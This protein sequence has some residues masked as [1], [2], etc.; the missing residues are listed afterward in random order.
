MKTLIKLLLILIPVV[1][2]ILSCEEDKCADENNM[3]VAEIV[4]YNYNCST[5]ILYFPNDTAKIKELLGASRHN[6]YQTVNLSQSDFEIGQLINV[7]VRPPENDELRACITLHPSY[8]YLNVYVSDYELYKD[9]YFIDDIELKYGECKTVYGQSTLCFDTVLED[10]RCPDGAVCVWEGNAKVQLALSGIGMGKHS[11]ELNTNQSFP[12]DTTI[13]HLNI[14]LVNV[15]PYPDINTVIKPEDYK[16]TLSVANIS[17]IESNAQ[18]LSF[19]PNKALCSWGW[20][21]KLD[22]DTIKSGDVLIGKTV[23]YEIN[24]PIDVFIQLGEK[25]KYCSDYYDIDRIIRI[26]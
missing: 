1:F 13:N 2:I 6:F 23:G 4:G 9:S 14:S 15:V 5:C 22:N 25:E 20:T 8:D 19:N 26:E 11:I 17:M 3:Y 12:T 18:V 21:I 24:Q 7:K 10:S 16:V